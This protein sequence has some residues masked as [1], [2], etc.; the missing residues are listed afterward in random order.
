MKSELLF[1]DLRKKSNVIILPKNEELV[2]PFRNQYI[3]FSEKLFFSVI[4][5][6]GGIIVDNWIRLYGC[7]NLNV[8]EKNRNYNI[9][10]EMDIIIAEDVVGGLFGLKDGI[11]YY[12][13]PDTLIWENLNIYYNQFIHWLINLEND[14]NL[15][16][17][18]FR[19]NNWDYDVKNIDLNSGMSFYP[20]LFTKCEINSR[21]KRVIPMDE[22]IGINMD[23]YNKYFN[24]TVNN[25]NQNKQESSLD[26]EI[27][28]DEEKNNYIKIIST[29]YFSEKEISDYFI[30]LDECRIY[31]ITYENDGKE[32][33]EF[34]K[35]LN[36][37]QKKKL[38]NYIDLNNLLN[39]TFNNIVFDASDIIEIC[40][41][42][43]KNVIKNASREFTNNEVC[44]FDDIVD[45][46]FFS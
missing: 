41:S 30:N 4:E 11:I 27:I 2:I 1:E 16:Y 25:I 42:G 44:I 19:W 5:N 9:T 45:I 40:I 12:F 10:N 43:K 31:N 20:F 29:G 21:S 15:F 26:M 17:K 8:L 22:I 28:K 35:E 3:R 23:M 32:K 34:Y 7:G 24:K 39:L 18:T 38:L 13:A 36:N 14:V 33:Y 6:C 37:D 46:V